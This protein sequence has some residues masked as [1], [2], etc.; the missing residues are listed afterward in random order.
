LNPEQQRGTD[1]QCQTEYELG[2]HL[3]SRAGLRSIPT[4]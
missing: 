2:H 4:R 3:I 1:E